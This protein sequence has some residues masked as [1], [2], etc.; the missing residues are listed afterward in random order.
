MLDPN[1]GSSLRQLDRD[2]TG[3]RPKLDLGVAIEDPACVLGRPHVDGALGRRRDL[4]LLA[5][6]PCA[7]RTI[8]RFLLTIA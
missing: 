1:P 6:H 7:S 2:V 4:E 5:G 8:R 3:E